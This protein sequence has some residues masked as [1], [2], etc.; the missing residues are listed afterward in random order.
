MSFFIFNQNSADNDQSNN[1]LNS[2]EQR[3]DFITE[4]VQWI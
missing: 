1:L 4:V 3:L 2:M